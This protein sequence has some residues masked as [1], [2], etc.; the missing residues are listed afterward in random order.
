MEAIRQTQK[1]YC[2]RALTAAIFAGFFFILIGHSPVGKGLIL[3]TLFSV[4]N[5]IIMGETIP[6][7]LNKSKGKTFLFS[8]GSILFRYLLLAV[9]LIMALKYEQYNLL[10]VVV[11]IF[12]VQ[13]FILADNFLSMLSSA[14]GK[15]VF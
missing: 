1:K 2:S 14:R 8:M 12:L 5:F 4:V 13:I 6:L 15:Q 9:P 7:K 3:G 11:G 10:A